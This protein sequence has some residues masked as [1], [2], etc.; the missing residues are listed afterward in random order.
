[1]DNPF[2]YWIKEIGWNGFL[3]IAFM[4]ILTYVVLIWFNKTR[5]A[6]ILKGI[7]IVLFV[8][9]IARQFNL[10]MISIVFEKFFGVIL[11]TFIV[12]F[13]E[14]IRHFFER[15]AAW[16]LNRD[17]GRKVRKTFS[18]AETEVLVRTA[19]ELARE[20]IGAL[21]V[22]RGK[23]IIE[24]HLEGG[25]ALDGKI[26][27]A[28]LKSLFDPHSSGHDGA[29]IIEEGKLLKFS[30]HLPLSK[31][32]SSLSEH[33]TRHAAGL[34]LSELCDSLCLI[35]SEEKGS[36][37]IAYEGE[38]RRVL[39]PKELTGL[40]DTFFYKIKP[41]QGASF[42]QDIFA[43]TSKEKVY[44]LFIACG[45][46]FVLVYGAG[47][48]YKNYLIPVPSLSLP[49]TWEIKDVYPKEVKVTL[50]GTR[51]AL[52]LIRPDNIQMNLD[53][54]LIEKKQQL[55]LHTDNFII[56]EGINLENV[57]PS[58][59]NMTLGHPGNAKNE[60]SGNLVD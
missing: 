1:M 24:R 31:N 34:G 12:I 42:W 39:E 23:D 35:V 57:N 45:L 3:D 60:Q 10:V 21:I 36:I 49:A 16:S 7:L 33:G 27:A 48:T 9:L 28:L 50:K 29:V 8:Y 19:F 11:I 6:F 2:I 51:R 38:L 58:V 40:I 4:S 25:V 30:C 43:R 52:Y 17:F 15:V 54:K 53:V 44:A 26:S 20:R 47:I 56:P 37:S 5:A 22:I 13:Q 32:L 46:W 55:R 18:H 59:V 41:K 14:E